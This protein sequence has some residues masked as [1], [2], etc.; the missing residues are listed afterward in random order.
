MFAGTV[1]SGGLLPRG[2]FRAEGW[3]RLARER[4]V[5]W[6]RRRAALARSRLRP[7]VVVA[8]PG[9]SCSASSV[10]AGAAGR[11]A[12]SRSGARRPASLGGTARQRP[13]ARRRSASSSASGSSSRC[14]ERRPRPHCSP[15]SAAGR[16]AASSSSA[17]TSSSRA[18]ARRAHSDAAAGRAHAGR[19]PLLIA[20]DQE[21]GEV[22]RLPWAGPR[23]SRPS[24][25][26]WAPRGS[27]RRRAQREGS[28]APPAST[29]ISRPSPTCPARDR[30]WRSSADIRVERDRRCR[31]RRGVR[32]G[33]CTARV[34][35]AV[36][37]FPGIGRATRNTDR[38]AVEIAA[39]RAE[40]DA[41]RP[42]SRSERR[43]RPACR[44]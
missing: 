27:G 15:G 7:G 32:A 16:S 17:P 29:S 1:R 14:R 44:S 42:R 28:S 6:L 30:S 37:H 43:S 4:A 23:S 8:L 24:S 38:A 31:C 26:G 13:A 33:A 11:G 40:L 9:L 21:G 36:K 18:P 25:G 19:P 5:A 35:A 2:P 20:T 39:T 41:Q 34:A 3:R 10:A 22:R 12:R